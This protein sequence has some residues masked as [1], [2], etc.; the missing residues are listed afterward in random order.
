MKLKTTLLLTALFAAGPALAQPEAPVPVPQPGAQPAAT[1]DELPEEAETDIEIINGVPVN[2]QLKAKLLEQEEALS[3]Q[4][5]IELSHEVLNKQK[6]ALAEQ[7]QAKA[8]DGWMDKDPLGHL[9]GEMDDLVQ[10]IESSK[11]DDST[12]AQGKDVVRKMDTLI[13][14]LEKAASACSS[15]SGSGQGQGQGQGP[16]NGNKPADESTLAAGPGGS[17]ELNAAGSGNN[18][19]ENLDP[20]Q[21]DA[22][23]RAT[24][25]LDGFPPEFEALLAEYYQRLA[26]EEALDAA[27]DEQPT[28]TE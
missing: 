19:F 6:Q 4:E 21:R 1:A 16:A 11:T 27:E 10:D 26:A 20:E 28:D 3:L 2:P 15:C 8:D 23:L 13:A 24:G 12:Q 9:E 22:I 7:E 17:G 25:D 14:L 18:R 5:L